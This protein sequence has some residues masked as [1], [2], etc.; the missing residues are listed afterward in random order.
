MNFIMERAGYVTL[1]PG[2]SERKSYPGALV[3]ANHDDFE[4]I[5]KTMFSFCSGQNQKITQEVK[6]AMGEG[7]RTNRLTPV[8]QEFARLKAQSGSG[9]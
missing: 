8:I 4:P 6:A 7:S 1:Y 9:P 5:V 3:H 2:I